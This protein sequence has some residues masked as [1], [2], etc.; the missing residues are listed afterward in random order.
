MKKLICLLMAAILLLCIAACGTKTEPET[1]G[2]P[3]AT[4]S[5]PSPSPEPSAPVG[6]GLSDWDPKNDS[7]YKAAITFR[8][9]DTFVKTD[10]G[11][12]PATLGFEG[13]TY[14][15]LD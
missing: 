4:V 3:S 10:E 13:S 8:A 14:I 7:N 6:L 9:G 11:M 12:K 15:P 5:S 2:P 1:S